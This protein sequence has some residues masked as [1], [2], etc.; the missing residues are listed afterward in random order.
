MERADQDWPRVTALDEPRQEVVT[1]LPV[2]NA[3]ERAVLAL[4]PSWT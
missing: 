1:L 4:M 3:R 2:R